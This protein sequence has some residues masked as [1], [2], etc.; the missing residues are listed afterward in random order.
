MSFITNSWVA[1]ATIARGVR[2]LFT[3]VVL[4]DV[5]AFLCVG[6]WLAFELFAISAWFLA[7]FAL[8]QYV[9]DTYFVCL[10]VYTVTSYFLEDLVCV[11]VVCIFVRKMHVTLALQMVP[12]VQHVACA[13]E[14]CNLVGVPALRGVNQ[15]PAQLAA[16]LLVSYSVGQWF[17]QPLF[18]YAASVTWDT[19]Q[20]LECPDRRYQSGEAESEDDSGSSFD[21]PCSSGEEDIGLYLLDSDRRVVSRASMSTLP[22]PLG[23]FVASRNEEWV[24]VDVKTVSL[25]RLRWALETQDGAVRRWVDLLYFS[26][27]SGRYYVTSVDLGRDPG[28]FYYVPVDLSGMNAFRPKLGVRPT[29]LTDVL[30]LRHEST[31]KELWVGLHDLD[32]PLSGLAASIVREAELGPTARL[33]R[34][35]VSGQCREDLRTRDSDERV[36]LFNRAYALPRT[37]RKSVV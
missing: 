27:A 33:E 28:S 15:R 14:I 37:D 17:V 1:L 26:H 30:E 34:Y 22:L 25:G 6:A 35:I 18:Q 16:N 10:P 3:F 12:V 7:L 23:F 5:V 2:S 4:C 32:G 31:W 19:L 20:L 24:L 21:E 8:C 9:T 13:L 36:C 29:D 11:F